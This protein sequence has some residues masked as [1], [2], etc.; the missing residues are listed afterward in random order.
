M[1]LLLS[2][3]L[4]FV[5]A[6]DLNGAQLEPLLSKYPGSLE[7]IDGDVS[8]RNVSERA[9]TRALTAFGHLDAIILT[10]AY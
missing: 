6:V 7:V 5:V 2:S 1:N 9:V 8:D 10:P 4:A 3:H